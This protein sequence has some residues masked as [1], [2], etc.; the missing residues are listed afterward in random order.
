MDSFTVCGQCF[1]YRVLHLVFILS[2]LN[3]TRV[4]R[5]ANDRDTGSLNALSLFQPRR[6][7]GF[8]K[9]NDFLFNYRQRDVMVND[10]ERGE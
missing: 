5:E 2:S 9:A 10:E 8:P 3:C 4:V 1:A 6:P 7:L